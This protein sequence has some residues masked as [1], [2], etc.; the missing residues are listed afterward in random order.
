M[1][2]EKESRKPGCADDSG[3]ADSDHDML[4]QFKREQS[5]ACSIHNRKQTEEVLALIRKHQKG[6]TR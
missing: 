5:R 2:A 3:P 6:R 1:T 4:A